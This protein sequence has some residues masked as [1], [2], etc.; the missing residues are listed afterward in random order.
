MQTKS[1]DKSSIKR[2]KLEPPYNAGDCGYYALFTGILYLALRSEKDN[3][4]KKTLDDSHAL[5]EILEIMRSNTSLSNS[6][7]TI[8]KQMLD[9]LASG[10]WDK[11]SYSELLDDFS[12]ALR[13]RLMNS[14]WGRGY[15]KTVIQ[16]GAWSFDHS[17]W[18]ELPSFKK[19]ENRIFDRMLEIVGNSIVEAEEAGEIRFRATLEVCKK[20]NE[21]E[22]EKMAEEVVKQHYGPGSQKV[23]V[24]RD[25]LEFL[26]QTLFSSTT[27]LFDE[28][29]VEIS[30]KGVS[31]CHW[32]LDLP[33]DQPATA[34]ID[35]ANKGYMKDLRVI[36]RFVIV[37]KPIANLNEKKEAL[38][39]LDQVCQS[40]I[41][42]FK[43]TLQIVQLQIK[44]G[45][46][47]VTALGYFDKEP[48]DEPTISTAILP[49][50]AEEDSLMTHYTQLV[51]LSKAIHQ[52]Q[53]KIAQLQEDIKVMKTQ[54]SSKVTGVTGFFATTSTI[55]HIE[56]DCDNSPNCS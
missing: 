27:L 29:G 3:G 10:E 36:D 28:K 35:V 26:C 13:N 42:E 25:F 2:I 41:A 24:S 48:P 40:N 22:L 21:N 39:E 49:F 16:E 51:L 23:W 38:K 30:S 32:Y 31:E 50:L 8:L 15:F 14:S 7:T 47:L 34:L 37:N 52:S 55:S 1:E 9:S 4:I 33:D 53:T 18:S 17:S 43:E 12:N 5:S 54:S 44:P 45:N 19:L 11:I 46:E 6:N 56:K 20:L